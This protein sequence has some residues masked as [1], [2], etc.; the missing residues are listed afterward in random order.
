MQAILALPKFE[1]SQ[2]QA[3]DSSPICPNAASGLVCFHHLPRSQPASGLR[4][5]PE[6][7]QQA[8]EVTA[9]LVERLAPLPASPR[10]TAEATETVTDTPV[11]SDKVAE[12]APED[13]SSRDDGTV[14]VAPVAET[15]DYVRPVEDARDDTVGDEPAPQSHARGYL[16]VHRDRANSLEELTAHIRSDKT[17]SDMVRKQALDWTELFWKNRQADAVNR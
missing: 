16:T 1:T 10:A 13:S 3:V 6:P 15:E 11:E 2:S 12:D 7:C 5:Q 9:H 4:S 17:I 14:E 8:A